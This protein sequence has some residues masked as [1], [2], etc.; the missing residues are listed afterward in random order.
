MKITMDFIMLRCRKF[1]GFAAIIFLYGFC[2]SLV[3]A[4]EI[5]IINVDLH[6]ADRNTL[7]LKADFRVEL[8]PPLIEALN[9]G[10]PLSFSLDLDVSEPRWYW[11][12]RSV[13]RW[14]QERRI[15]YNPLTRT[16]RFYIGGIY[17]TFT[18]LDEAI[19]ALE[20]IHPLM[21]HLDSSLNQKTSYQAQLAFKLDIS[22]L[23][24]PFQLDA[25]Y[26][27]EWNL[28]SPVRKWIY[29]P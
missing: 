7:I 26:S 24:K 21:I 19:T 6:G 13:L 3:H 15:S 14:H 23:P 27:S 10:V 8:P 11:F 9:R 18:N 2:C 29:H 25:L 20:T 28:A 16:Y 5:A 12:D 1:N 4:E 17:L 22:Q